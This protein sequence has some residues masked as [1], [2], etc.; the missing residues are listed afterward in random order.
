MKIPRTANKEIKTAKNAPEKFFKAALK[1]VFS[2]IA[3]SAIG[4]TAP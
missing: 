4:N 2:P 3:A 1:F